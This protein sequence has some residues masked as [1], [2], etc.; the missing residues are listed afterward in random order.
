[1]QQCFFIVDSDR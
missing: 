1:M